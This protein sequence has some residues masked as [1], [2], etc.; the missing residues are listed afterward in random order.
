MA[1]PTVISLI[2]IIVITCVQI[3]LTGAGHN[4]KRGFTLIELLVTITIIGV[5]AAL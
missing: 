5:L 2:V 1:S 4:M 3:Q